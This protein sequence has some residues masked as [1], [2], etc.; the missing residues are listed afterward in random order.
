MVGMRMGDID[1][2]QSLSGGGDP[3]GE[4]RGL[5]I[6]QESIDEKRIRSAV[7][8][9]RRVRDPFQIILARRHA[10]GR[11]RAS[12]YEQLPLEGRVGLGLSSHRRRAPVCFMTYALS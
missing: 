11:A 4:F 8:Q 5:R 12:T 2:G 6:G 3:V 9:G 7:Y 10:L 1:R